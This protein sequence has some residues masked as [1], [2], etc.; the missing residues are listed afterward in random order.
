MAALEDLD[1]ALATAK[2][3][4]KVAAANASTADANLKAALQ[5]LGL[6]PTPPVR[7]GTPHAVTNY[8]TADL[9]RL[10]DAVISTKSA[11]ASKKAAMDAADTALKGAM[12]SSKV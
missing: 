1:Q 10:A 7:A 2:S 8:R 12:K 4:H 11:L 3:D 5:Q 9:G 6:A